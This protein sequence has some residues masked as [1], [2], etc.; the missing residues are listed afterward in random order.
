MLVSQEILQ[1]YF[2]VETAAV[3]GTVA[4]EAL[5]L[6]V[7]AAVGTAKFSVVAKDSSEQQ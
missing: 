3:A 4:A 1:A 2:V 5:I 6:R 7:V